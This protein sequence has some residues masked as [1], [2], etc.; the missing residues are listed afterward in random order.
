MPATSIP[1]KGS[2]SVVLAADTMFFCTQGMCEIS[3]DP[4][5]PD[6]AW[7]AL[8]PGGAA[9]VIGTGATVRFRNPVNRAARL[10][11]MAV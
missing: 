1:G 8:Y 11:R 10:E 6:A 9:L 4:D 2:G 7:F 5:Q 3:T